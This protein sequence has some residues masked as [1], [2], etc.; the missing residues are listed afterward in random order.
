[1]E[2][3]TLE[4]WLWLGSLSSTV[5]CQGPAVT[6]SSAP[7]DLRGVGSI[8]CPEILICCLSAS[9]FR[10]KELSLHSLPAHDPLRRGRQALPGR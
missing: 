5:W 1:M 3:L 7:T 6:L 10:A 4:G 2:E 8:Q 9:Y